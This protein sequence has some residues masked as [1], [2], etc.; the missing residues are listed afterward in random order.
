[1][2][3]AMFG[4]LFRQGQSPTRKEMHEL[5]QQLRE[6]LRAEIKETVNAAV[7][8]ITADLNRQIDEVNHRIDE[9]N[10]R[11]DGLRQDVNRVLAALANHDHIDGRVIV[12]VQPDAEPA[13]V[14][15]N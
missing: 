7:R 13:P 2:L 8:E 14:A 12:T 3:V 4:I 1:M 9:V 10:Y 6:E 5:H 11:I 15:D